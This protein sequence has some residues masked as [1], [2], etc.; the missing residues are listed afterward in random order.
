M[1]RMEDA[2]PSA[3]ALTEETQDAAMASPTS[4]VEMSDAQQGPTPMGLQY[5]SADEHTLDEYEE[6]DYESSYY[7]DGEDAEGPREFFGGMRLH[8]ASTSARIPHLTSATALRWW[9]SAEGTAFASA[10]EDSLRT[11]EE[12][13]LQLEQELH[14]LRA[15][16][17]SLLDVVFRNRQADSLSNNASRLAPDEV[18]QTRLPWTSQYGA[19][20]DEQRM[21]HLMDTLSNLAVENADMRTDLC[22]LWTVIADNRNHV[23]LHQFAYNGQRCD[24]LRSARWTGEPVDTESGLSIDQEGTPSSSS[25]HFYAQQLMRE[26]NGETRPSSPVPSQTDGSDGEAMPPLMTLDDAWESDGSI[27]GPIDPRWGPYSPSSDDGDVTIRPRQTERRTDDDEDGDVLSGRIL[28]DLQLN[29][30]M[31]ERLAAMAGPVRGQRTSLKVTSQVRPR[32]DLPSDCMVIHGSV[33]GLVGTILL[34]SGSSINAISPAF[35]GVAGVTAHTLEHPVGLQLGCVG[36][37]S[38]INFGAQVELAVGNTRFPVYLDVVNLDHYDMVL[39]IPF[40]RTR[41]VV[42]DFGRNEV[43]F[44]STSV[45]TLEGEGK[46]ASKSRPPKAGP[47]ASK[48]RSAA[49][50]PSKP[51]PA[52]TSLAP[53]PRAL[54]GTQ[55]E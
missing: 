17:D 8:R 14:T 6:F 20:S 32:P 34:D 22:T 35:G 21:A 38:K 33:N 43:R 15:N 2:E 55:P 27:M 18:F 5:E 51:R 30:M 36:S 7:D 40:M 23:L 16:V 52:G 41:D 3:T 13:I 54:A 26:R 25:D 31:V 24:A 50:G 1:R 44:G 45:P 29:L 4:D 39:G 49:A 48:S 11:N 37:R 53:K 42:L 46:R 28:R 12:R 9:V 10:V 47:Q 19:G